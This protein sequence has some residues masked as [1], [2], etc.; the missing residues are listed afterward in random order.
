LNQ[1]LQLLKIEHSDLFRPS[2]I[3]LILAN[4]IPLYGVIF[5]DWE[6]FPLMLLF[7]MENVIVGI[8]NVLKMLTCQPDTP[9]KWAGKGGAVFF[10]C[11]HYGLFTLVH[12]LFVFFM[13]GGMVE[14]DAF[15]PSATTL[16]HTIGG[17]QMVWGILALFMSHAISFAINYIGKGEYKTSTLNQLMSEPYTRVVILHLTI[18]FG[19]FLM[20]LLG[21]PIGGLILL[22]AIKIFVDI[23]AHL[24]QRNKHSNTDAKQ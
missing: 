15:F 23:Q 17:F 9:I 6:V 24:R 10:F 22:I 18:I 7:W 13:F 14:D 20:M 16:T 1:L 11:V 5:L 2:V 21:S 19:G 4:L 3:I 12:G 8:F